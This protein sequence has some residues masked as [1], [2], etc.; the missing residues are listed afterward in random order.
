MKRIFLYMFII[1]IVIITGCENS[2]GM[3]S[4]KH[5]LSLYKDSAIEIS[6]DINTIDINIDSGNIQIYCWDKKEIKFEAKHNIRDNK[7]SE[8]LEKQ[9]KKFSIISKEQENTFLFAVDYKGNIKN[10]QDIYTDIKLTLPRRIKKIDITQQI[11]VLK[12]E[13]KFEG[14][15]SAQ[16]DSVNSEIKAMTG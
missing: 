3:A 9:L 4:P 8:E 2:E 6:K 1:L 15:I 13:D 14:D 5:G 7:T 16:L 11:G 12:I 10:T